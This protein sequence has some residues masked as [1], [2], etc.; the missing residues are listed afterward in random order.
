MTT[1]PTARLPQL[2]DRQTLGSL[3][4][5]PFCLGLVTSPEMVLAAF[6]AGINFF[7]VSCDLHWPLY[8]KLRV[9][10]KLLLERGV[11]DR[12]VIAATTYMVHE[13][14]MVGP[15]LELLRELRALE[16][17]DVLVAGTCYAHDAPGRL[18]VLTQLRDGPVGRMLRPGAIAASFH[19]R[20]AALAAA[21]ARVIDLAFVRHNP[22]HPGGRR[23][24]YPHLPVERP[25]LFGF[26]STLGSL[27]PAAVRALGDGGWVPQIADYYRYALSTAPLDGVLCSLNRPEELAALTGALAR[28]PLTADEE[29]RLEQL[30]P[31]ARQARQAMAAAA[32]AALPR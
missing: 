29:R 19:D 9:G 1:I 24:L 16:R 13:A 6:D 31:V 20:S 26:K 28:G 4:V 30:A 11:R 3:Q 23:D 22:L 27:P 32:T 12:I 17:I 7:F 21:R 10:L 5:S 8:D 25:R 2:T 18:Q 14:L 15:F